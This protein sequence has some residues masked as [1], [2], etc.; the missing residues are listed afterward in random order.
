MFCTMKY[1]ELSSEFQ[2]EV[3]VPSQDILKN[4]IEKKRKK[5]YFFGNFL[6]ADFWQNP[7]Y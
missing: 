5:N 6:P 3:N 1:S 2:M 7:Y 4:R